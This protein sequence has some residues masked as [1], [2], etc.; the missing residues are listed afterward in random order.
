MHLLNN[1]A[2]ANKRTISS[3][4]RQKTAMIFNTGMFFLMICL[5]FVSCKKSGT[6]NPAT[7]TVPPPPSTPITKVTKKV[8]VI[9]YDPFIT[10]GKRAHEFFNWYNPRTLTD[11][12]ITDIKTS[13]GGYI[14]YVIEE[15]RDID[16]IP[17][18]ADGFRYTAEMYKQNMQT[19][20]GWHHPDEMD[21]PAMIATQNIPTL[22]NQNKIDE[23]WMFGGPYFGFWEG[24]MAGPRAF[25]INGGIY[26]AIAT[27]SAFAIMGFNY[28]RTVDQ[29]L[30]SYCHRTEATMTKVYNGWDVGV[31]NTPWAKFAANVTQS[32][33]H[34]GVG[35]CHYPPNATSDYDYANTTVVMSTADDWYNY[36]NLTGEKKPVN[37][38][39]WGGPNYHHNYMKWWF[40][41]FPRKEGKD[42][43]GKLL[44]WWKF[45][46]DFNEYLLK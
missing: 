1:L 17:V 37:R 20:S 38:E 29:M 41:H 25:N 2:F 39:T 24:A 30:H 43:E 7:Q 16:E 31:L 8:I 13:S 33:G 21:Y 23:V 5:A 36:P 42:T 40:S 4:I 27:D 45:V 11:Q 32:N 35:S 46:V 15:W 10:P 44:N 12:F 22:I 28:E 26:P 3:G 18:K 14:E 9:N 34:A 6:K 19:N